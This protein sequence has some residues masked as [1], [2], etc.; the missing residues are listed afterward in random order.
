[1]DA[2]KIN[3]KTGANKCERKSESE[4]KEKV[5][6]LKADL[7]EGYLWRKKFS[8]KEEIPRWKVHTAWPMIPGYTTKHQSENIKMKTLKQNTKNTIT[9]QIFVFQV[10][11]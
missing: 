7:S 5:K 9:A 3:E 2:M 8:A 10:S 4:I 1:M 11:V 6:V